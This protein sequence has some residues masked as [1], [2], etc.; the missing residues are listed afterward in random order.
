MNHFVLEAKVETLIEAE[1]FETAM[2]IFLEDLMQQGL[3]VNELNAEYAST[4][5]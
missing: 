1:D 3:I 5:H 4:I 2:S